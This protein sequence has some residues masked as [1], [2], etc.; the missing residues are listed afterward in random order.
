MLGS[1]GVSGSPVAGSPFGIAS[2]AAF[3]ATAGSD[4]KEERVSPRG[5]KFPSAA[6]RESLGVVWRVKYIARSSSFLSFIRIAC[7]DKSKRNQLFLFLSPFGILSFG[8]IIGRI[9]A[10]NAGAFSDLFLDKFLQPLLFIRIVGHFFGD[11]RRNDHNSFS[12]THQNIPRHNQDAGTADGHIDVH[13]MVDFKRSGGVWRLNIG[14]K[15]DTFEVWRVTQS[16]ICNKTGC[17]ACLE[18]GG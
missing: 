11:L 16:S 13:G 17:A 5:R 1:T 8:L 15:I 9:D 14:G 12:V 4:N 3:M 2:K 6:H 18:A 10:E 7:H